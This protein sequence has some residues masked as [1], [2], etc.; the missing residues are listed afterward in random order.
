LKHGPRRDVQLLDAHDWL[1]QM[2]VD[3]YLEA[4]SSF[5][6]KSVVK[7]FSIKK[8]AQTIGLCDEN[9]ENDRPNK[10]TILT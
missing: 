6:V 5:Q 3:C 1:I 7:G 10:V 8:N 9:S 2:V 4:F